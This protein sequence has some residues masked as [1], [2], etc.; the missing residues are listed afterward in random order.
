MGFHS[1]GGQWPPATKMQGIIIKA[2]SGRPYL[3]MWAKKTILPI[4]HNGVPEQSRQ[5]KELR[6]KRVTL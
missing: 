6:M 1:R 4:T 3:K 5:M 2:A